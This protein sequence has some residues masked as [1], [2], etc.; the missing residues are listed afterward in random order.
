MRFVITSFYPKTK[1][2]LPVLA[3][4]VFN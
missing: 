3:K 1:P 2:S 4:K